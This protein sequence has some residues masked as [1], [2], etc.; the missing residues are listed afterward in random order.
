MGL[1]AWSH[2]SLSSSGDTR[3]S[4]T[5]SSYVQVRAEQM[6]SVPSSLFSSVCGPSTSRACERERQT[7]NVQTWLRRMG[8][9]CGGGSAT[10][11]IVMLCASTA[12]PFAGQA[13]VHCNSRDVFCPRRHAKPQ[14]KSRQAITQLG[15]ASHL[16]WEGIGWVGLRTRLMMRVLRTVRC[17]VANSTSLSSWRASILSSAL[18]PR[19]RHSSAQ[20]F[21]TRASC[22]MFAQNSN[23]WGSQKCGALPEEFL[24]CLEPLRV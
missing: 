1:V 10:T 17:A 12:R 14:K 9:V 11:M 8:N 23:V 7:H 20:T 6:L 4:G 3:Q 13:G 19:P 21:C 18:L 22:R 5:L 2:R 15:D 16:A 24:E